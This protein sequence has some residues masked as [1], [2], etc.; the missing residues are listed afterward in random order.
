MSI[1]FTLKIRMVAKEVTDLKNN[2]SVGNTD[3]KYL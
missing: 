2:Y 3:A 1:S